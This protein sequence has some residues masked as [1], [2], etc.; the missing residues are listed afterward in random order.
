VIVAL[1]VAEDGPYIGLNNIDP[2]PESRDARKY[3]GS[4][5]VIAHP[6]CERWGRYWS[7]GP[8]AKV[9]RELGDDNGCFEAAMKAVTAYGGVLEHPEASHAWAEFGLLRPNPNGGWTWDE[10]NGGW[11]CQVEQ[12]HYGHPA[13]K[14]TWLFLK[15]KPLR[16]YFS[17]TTPPE[18]MWG[19]STGRRRL[20]EGFH[21]SDERKR[22]RSNGQKPT[23]RLSKK[24]CVHSPAEFV[25]A[26]IGLIEN[27]PSQTVSKE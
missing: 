23:K 3:A 24:E 27:K 18:L 13:R 15:S 22:V 25:D 20:D 4:R 21:S 26:L 10:N 6:P 11:V 2:W 12:G 14:K 1:F 16:D 5:P 19:P 8:S 7:G 9:R 17:W